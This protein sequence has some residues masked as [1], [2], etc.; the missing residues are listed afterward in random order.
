M[1]YLSEN[2]RMKKQIKQVRTNWDQIKT[3]KKKDDF[4]V[5]E[6]T[7]ETNTGDQRVKAKENCVKSQ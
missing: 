2:G 5:T 4:V 1:K 7:E 3:D 6:I